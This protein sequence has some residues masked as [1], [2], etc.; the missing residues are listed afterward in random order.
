MMTNAEA[1]KDRKETAELSYE[2]AMYDR[3]STV[4]NKHNSLCLSGQ[5]ADEQL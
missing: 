2:N 4:E 1:V 3:D 5:G